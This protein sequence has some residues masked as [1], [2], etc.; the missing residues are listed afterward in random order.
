MARLT[1]AL[2]VI[3]VEQPATCGDRNDVVHFGRQGRYSA[4]LTVLAERIL[5]EM[6]H[7]KLP[8]AGIVAALFR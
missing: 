3:G 7:P 5:P 8:P 4:G 1:K 6:D 2:E